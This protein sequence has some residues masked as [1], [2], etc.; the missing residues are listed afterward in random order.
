M[1]ILRGYSMYG[2]GVRTMGYEAGPPGLVYVT[3][4]LTCLYVPFVPLRRGLC[5]FLRMSEG[6]MSREVP[7][8]VFHLMFRVPLSGLS[9]LTT[10]VWALATL[11]LLFG[12][13]V[14][15]IVA[16]DGRA[17]TLGEMIVIFSCITAV[18]LFPFWRAR[19]ERLYLE[20]TREG[21]LFLAD[22][23][24]APGSGGSVIRL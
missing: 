7:T 9:I 3:L 15:L 10:W 2:V 5:R 1:A 13:L 23:S 22:G 18:A 16:T 12:P 14:Y 17:A 21:S 8:P 20:S 4:W 6:L 19:R 11:V 24:E